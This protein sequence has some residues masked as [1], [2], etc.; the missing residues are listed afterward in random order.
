MIP[1]IEKEQGPTNNINSKKDQCLL[2][3][4]GQGNGNPANRKGNNKEKNDNR[5]KMK[6]G[7][8]NEV[9]FFNRKI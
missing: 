7:L 5:Q 1:E 9:P 2:K 6:D 4:D 3:N 8:L